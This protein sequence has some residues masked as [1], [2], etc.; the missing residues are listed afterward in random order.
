MEEAEQK[1]YVGEIQTQWEHAQRAAD[2]I[3]EWLKG[4]NNKSPRVLFGEIHTLLT[5]AG[6]ISKLFWPLLKTRG[7]NETDEQYAQ[8][9][10]ASVRGEQLRQLFHIQPGHL[11]EKRPLRDHLEHFDERVDEFLVE[12]KAVNKQR[13]ADGKPPAGYSDLFVAPQWFVDKIDI[14]QLG[15]ILRHFDQETGIFTFRGKPY[16]I[17]E[18]YQEVQAIGAKSLILLPR[19]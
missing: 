17:K 4:T 1:L 10:P 14:N 8:R 7:K 9:Q 19:E 15:F 11:F 18:I 5:H 6:N 2:R 13:A 12:W 16:D 3:D